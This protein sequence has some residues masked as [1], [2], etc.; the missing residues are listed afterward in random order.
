M[1]GKE[2]LDPATLARMQKGIAG[3]LVTLSAV[4]VGSALMG[5][6]PAPS[7]DGWAIELG[8]LPSFRVRIIGAFAIYGGGGLLP[9]LL[10]A[11]LVKRLLGR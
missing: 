7:I 1:D 3:V 9:I 6:W 10:V 5:F 8:L 4:C 11:V 2:E